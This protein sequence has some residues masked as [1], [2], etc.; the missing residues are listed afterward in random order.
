MVEVTLL[1]T[2]I[3]FAGLF[4]E[5]MF[6]YLGKIKKSKCCNNEIEMKQEKEE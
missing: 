6:A 1:V 4:M 3:G 5:R 2:I